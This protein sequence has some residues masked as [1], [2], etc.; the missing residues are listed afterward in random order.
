MTPW[1]EELELPYMKIIAG[2]KADFDGVLL[3]PAE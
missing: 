2:R 1:E 3:E